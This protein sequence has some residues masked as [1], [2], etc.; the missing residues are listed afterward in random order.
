MD[1]L[2]TLHLRSAAAASSPPSPPP[3][4]GGRP[5]ASSLITDSYARTSAPSSSLSRTR[6]S[7][8]AGQGRTDPLLTVHD[9]S[10]SFADTPSDQ[11]LSAA[12]G[13]THGG[14]EDTGAGTTLPARA[15]S[16]E[17]F[18]GTSGVRVRDAASSFFPLSSAMPSSSNEDEEEVGDS[19]L[20][21]VEDAGERYRK[22][23]QVLAAE[24]GEVAGSYGV[25]GNFMNLIV[26]HVDACFVTDPAEAESSH[27]K[28]GT[29]SGGG[30]GTRKPW[31]KQEQGLW[32]FLAARLVCW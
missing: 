12:A 18:C 22:A 8:T 31:R 28:K 23:L 16:G 1:S 10:R 3:S 24:L 4:G 11:G 30:C 6:F 32:H 7:E 2:V 27:A 17:E 5:V 25:V 21:W 26:T 20:R 14:G 19:R 15:P 29:L 9:L 13:T